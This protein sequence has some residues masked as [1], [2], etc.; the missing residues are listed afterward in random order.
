M[1]KELAPTNRMQPTYLG[2]PSRVGSKG[3]EVRQRWAGCTV[4]E[5]R[6]L[7]KEFGL[8]SE[9]KERLVKDLKVRCSDLIYF[10]FV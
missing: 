5:V 9:S 7:D 10:F 1:G 4:Q 8:Y 6:G 3:D 2:Q